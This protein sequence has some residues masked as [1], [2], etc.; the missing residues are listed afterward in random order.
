MAAS[1]EA[2]MRRLVAIGN[3][4]GIGGVFQAGK[5]GRSDELPFYLPQTPLHSLARGLRHAGGGGAVLRPLDTV[6]AEVEHIRLK[7][8]FSISQKEP[9]S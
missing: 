2:G 8:P 4:S 5:S 3:C 7:P 9:P 1:I 6:H